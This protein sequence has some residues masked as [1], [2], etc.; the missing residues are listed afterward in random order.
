MKII[1]ATT[2]DKNAFFD[3]TFKEDITINPYSHVGLQHIVFEPNPILFKV[4]S[5]NNTITYAVKTGNKR[6]VSLVPTTYTRQNSEEL[7]TNIQV[8]LNADLNLIG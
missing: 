4:D 1:R 7:L 3:T 5:T 2:T 8:K 6:V